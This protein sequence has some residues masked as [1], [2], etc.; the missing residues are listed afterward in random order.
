MSETFFDL[1]KASGLTQEVLGALM[2][3]R[4]GR[5]VEAGWGQKKI[6]RFEAG[7]AEPTLEELGALA[8]ELGVDPQIVLM[9]IKSKSGAPGEAS[10][11]FR[12]VG[13][14][15]MRRSLMAVCCLSRSRAQSL[16]ESFAMMQRAIE[17]GLTLCAFVPYPNT[18]HLPDLADHA[19]TLAGYYRRIRKSVSD[20][21]LLFKRRLPEAYSH[22]VAL[23][24]PRSELMKEAVILMPPIFR[25][26]SLTIEESNSGTITKSLLEWTPSTE[27][28]ISRPILA[29]GVHSLDE[30]I[31]A[32]EAFFGGILSHWV[33]TNELS[34][35]DGYWEKIR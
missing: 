29:T 32:W 13:A 24:F 33:G 12:T 22:R 18:L 6:S 2:A 20:A 15:D 7:E 14:P 31:E 17:S 1:R 16:D 35:A 34:T 28:D 5:T 23:Y 21:N 11:I 19:E 30:Q 4:L 26:F 27:Q 10:T 25:Q 8:T 3:A 9:S